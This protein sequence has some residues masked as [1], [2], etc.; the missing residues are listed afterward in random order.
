MTTLRKKEK[1]LPNIRGLFIYEAIKIGNEVMATAKAKITNFKKPEYIST[2]N[3]SEVFFEKYYTIIVYMKKRVWT[4]VFIK[5]VHES[6]WFSERT[7]T[8]SH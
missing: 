5:G 4:N 1:V 7:Y 3:Y 6:V 8:G 2:E